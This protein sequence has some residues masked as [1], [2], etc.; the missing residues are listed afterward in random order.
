MYFDTFFYSL[1]VSIFFSVVFTTVDALI[2]GHPQGAKKVSI[3]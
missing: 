3:I 1:T 2:G